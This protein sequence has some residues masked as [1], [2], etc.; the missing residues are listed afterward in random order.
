MILIGNFLSK[1]LI[2]KKDAHRSSDNTF[3]NDSLY[4]AKLNSTA[5][6]SYYSK[7]EKSN[8]KND[9]KEWFVNCRNLILFIA[10]IL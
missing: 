1:F 6:N 3:F 5:N 7:A 4:R 9:L 2:K 10:N 8:N